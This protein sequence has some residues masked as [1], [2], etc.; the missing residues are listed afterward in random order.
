M[1]TD[2]TVRDLLL[3]MP[4]L[5]G[6]V[7]R[8]P[9]PEELRAFDLAPRHLSML[10]LLL[11]DGP[12]TVKE[13]AGM[14]RLAPTTVSL[15]VSDLSRK[16]VLVRREDDADRRRRIIDISAS[17][18][19]AIVQWLSPGA[20]AWRYA[21]AP[22]SPAQQQMFVDTLLRYEHAVEARED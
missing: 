17:S 4:R 9:V 15:I 2:D 5:V 18:R 6:R 16:G 13:L 1:S 14:L 8:L 11:L 10:S 3:V 22:L 7:K 12:L 19:P 20:Q 21:L